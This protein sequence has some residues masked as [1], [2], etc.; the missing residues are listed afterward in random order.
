MNRDF[1]NFRNSLAGLIDRYKSE[2]PAERGRILETILMHYR[3]FI[4]KNG[5]GLINKNRDLDDLI[6]DVA[7][8][9]IKNKVLDRFNSTVG[10]D[11]SGYIPY[12][13]KLAIRRI[14]IY[15]S[16]KKRK[17]SGETS[18][19]FDTQES[20]YEKGML[21]IPIIDTLVAPDNVEND[22][23]DAI[24]MT[25]NIA[26]AKIGISRL[27]PQTRIQAKVILFTKNRSL[28]EA[29]KKLNI[30]TERVRQILKQVK[31]NSPEN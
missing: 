26:R 8:F 13:I 4:A 22:A 12:Y 10:F 28:K 19:L 7:E 31:A 9:F 6:Q 16:R 20:K 11:S 5:S 24:Y 3:K 25:E 30:S 17:S 21:K 2:T 18:S 14:C 29:G 15:E 23:L 27:S 1:T